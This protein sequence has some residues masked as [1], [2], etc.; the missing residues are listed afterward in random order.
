MSKADKMLLKEG[1]KLK[2]EDEY[3]IK[4]EYH[5]RGLGD[6][7]YFILC[8][9]KKA[10]IYFHK[11]ID[12]NSIGVNIGLHKAIN[13]KCEELRM[14]LKKELEKNKD[15]KDEFDIIFK[16]TLIFIFTIISIPIYV[17]LQVILLIPMKI[18]YWIV[19]RFR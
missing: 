10:K 5:S 3:E 17:I 11:D 9:C 14:D 6:S 8:F 18:I 12:C 13:K 7:F 1:Y 19:R 16:D 4:Y 15:Y 2:Y